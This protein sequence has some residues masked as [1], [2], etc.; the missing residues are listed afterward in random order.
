MKK[1]S[2][3]CYQ[4]KKEKKNLRYNNKILKSYIYI[5]YLF[6]QKELILMY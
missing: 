3:P 5:Y 1:C 4:K 6:E 2:L